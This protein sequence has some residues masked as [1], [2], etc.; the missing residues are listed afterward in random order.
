MCCINRHWH[1]HYWVAI[2]GKCFILLCF[3]L[4]VLVI[5]WGV[6]FRVVCTAGLW[7][8]MVWRPSVRTLIPIL[9]AAISLYLARDLNASWHRYSPCELALWKRFSGTEVKGQDHSEAKCTYPAKGKLTAI[10][11][12]CVQWRS[13][14]RQCGI[15]VWLVV[16]MLMW[17]CCISSLKY[18]VKELWSV[19]H[20]AGSTPC[21]RHESI[22]HVAESNGDC[23][24]LC[25]LQV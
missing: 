2:L 20:N 15:G 4:Q 9:C 7:P 18:G 11:P 13:T 5:R 8:S 16:S 6:C 25:I 22:C 10:R 3:C 23:V 1:W 17:L 14:D 24:C 12:L 19:V 21:N